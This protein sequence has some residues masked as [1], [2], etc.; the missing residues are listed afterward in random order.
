[1]ISP[2]LFNFTKNIL[3]ICGYIFFFSEVITGAIRYYFSKFG[4]T[5]LVYFPK[6]LLILSILFFFTTIILKGK[7]PKRIFLIFMLL[8]ISSIT[9]ILFVGNYKQITFGVYILIPF[10]YGIIIGPIFIKNIEKYKNFIFTLWI[11]AATGV[12]INFFYKWPW[13]GFTYDL[14]SI[15]VEG[16]REWSTAGFERLSGFGRISAATA[17]QIL[18]LGITLFLT[19]KSLIFRSIIWLLSGIAIVLTTTKTTIGIWLFL[20]LIFFLSKIL[21]LK[22]FKPL[23]IILSLAGILLPLS[24]LYIHYNL[25]ISN[26]Y[27]FLL[28]ASFEMRLT[29]TWPMTF[30][31]ITNYGNSIL[32]RGIGG[33]GSAQQYFE[34]YIYSPADNLSLYLYAVFG[35]SGIV[36][37]I[38]IGVL[39]SLK[40]SNSIYGKFVFFLSVACLLQGLSLSIIEDP[41]FATCLG[42][43][44]SFLFSSSKYFKHKHYIEV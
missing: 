33:I 32:G 7:I 36:L 28:F 26:F 27:T 9:S 29:D 21:T 43:V 30:D 24:T 11:I 4:L 3:L 23:P 15:H 38:I 31:L 42:M 18:L 44:I 35:L 25:S 41:F 19:I 22:F 13:I 16:S 12:F 2:K 37:L 40:T 1:M 14:G 34:E 5:F 20:T 39:S 6:I 10:I 17:S 8:L